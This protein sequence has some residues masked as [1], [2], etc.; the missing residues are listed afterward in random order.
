[1]TS[2][3]FAG[4]Q[5]RAPFEERYG[6]RVRKA[7]GDIGWEALMPMGSTPRGLMLDR[8][9]AMIRSSR[10]AIY[11]VTVDNGN[12]WFELGISLA[13]RQPIAMLTE[14]EPLDLPDLL[15]T[16]FLHRYSG[17]DNCCEAAVAFLQ[18]AE[19]PPMIPSRIVTP[20]PDLTIVVGR[21]SRTDVVADALA[22][23]GYKVDVLNPAAVR[24]VDEAVQVAEIGQRIVV[25]RA[26]GETWSG[27]DSMVSLILLGGAYELNRECAL[28]AGE[29]E[30]IPSDCPQLVVRGRDESDLGNSVAA[31]LRRPRPGPPPSGTTRPKLSR[32]LTR[33]RAAMI[34]RLIEDHGEVAFEAEPGYGKTLML[35]QV[36]HDLQLPT[37]WI[38]A[39]DDWSV[40]K[41]VEALVAAVGE[42]VPG[43]GWNAL[44]SLRASRS[45][46]NESVRESATILSSISGRQ[47]GESIWGNTSAR[48]DLPAVLLVIDDI[49]KLHS[50]ADSL[51]AGML[52]TSPKWMR[53][54]VAG[55]GLPTKVGSRFVR[56]GPP[57]IRAGDLAFDETE[58]ETFLRQSVPLIE[59]GWLQLLHSRTEG[60]PI[61]LAVI[62]AWLS[63]HPDATFEQLQQMTRGDRRQ[64]YQIFATDY[65]TSLDPQVQADLLKASLPLRLD[66][67]VAVQLF[68]VGGGQRLRELSLGPYFLTEDSSGAFRYHTL[69]REFLLKRWSEERG[70]D[71]LRAARIDLAKWYSTQGDTVDAFQV[72]VEAEDWET[73]ALA[74]EPISKVLA[75]H[76][77][78]RLL[79]EILG[80]LPEATLRSRRRLWESW[81]TALSYTGDAR[82]LHELSEL[83]T[84]SLG[85]E[86]DHAIA[87][88]LYAEGRYERGQLTDAEMAR[89]CDRVA[90]SLGD[91][92]PVV[93]IQARLKSL[94]A[95]SVHNADASAWPG[96]AEEAEQLG[97]WADDMK[98]PTVAAAA[99]GESAELVTRMYG[100]GISQEAMHLKV[101]ESMGY[102]VRL[103]A[104][105]AR[106]RRYVVLAQRAEDLFKEAFARAEKASRDVVLAQV[107]LHYSRF[108]TYFVMQA[109]WMGQASA[110]AIAEDMTRQ[111]E[112]AIRYALLAAQAYSERGLPRSAAI[113]LNTAGQAAAAID[114]RQRRDDFCN[115]AV[116]IASEFGYEEIADMAIRTRLQPTPLDVYRAAQ[117]PPPLHQQTEEWRK[118]MLEG[119]LDAAPLTSEQR[120]QLRPV[121]ERVLADDLY[122]S[123]LR[124]ETCEHLAL[125]MDLTGRRIGP[126]DTVQPKRS[127]TCRLLGISLIE[128]SPQGQPLL[129]RFRSAFCM[130]CEFRSP[131][132]TSLGRA[133]D[134]EDIFAPMLRFIRDAEAG[135]Q[136]KRTNPSP[137]G[138]IA[139]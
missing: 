125:L 131:A 36:A 70:L 112:T 86:G 89:A 121:Q 137:H 87:E 28:A 78:G 10:R 59:A 2:W 106:A 101:L 25:V 122:A 73:A 46:L 109:I 42:H 15:R 120:D 6:V 116:E 54:A 107:Q 100:T 27:P 26:T 65:F 12:V 93:A 19:V 91:R 85:D 30:W 56:T 88:L 57:P 3:F 126:F 40:D 108:M 115:R 38:T 52:E 29:G 4:F 16:P 124:E 39:G 97:R 104:R 98:L 14:I 51:V 17:D 21:G 1:M 95:R 102:A 79:M 61:A 127:V 80:R 135:K 105:I 119:M 33:R 114:D 67:S 37:A 130:N 41:L 74:V 53:I 5:Y 47:L 58:T 9:A 49:H 118:Q 35:D 94:S 113:A 8:I 82:A 117:N 133:D 62:R 60:W 13:R 32:S 7:A 48:A 55:R 90:D 103:E 69:F 77:D 24:S 129:R 110:G 64:I 138:V 139:L 45:Q 136:P 66:D 76:G 83:T 96:L 23:E 20:K 50:E 81:A 92:Y 34:T 75:S 22:K 71:S 43:F 123:R 63:L 128:R 44:S 31:A 132:A 134:D 11:D 84:S 18:L 99:Y 68:G 111:G 72:A